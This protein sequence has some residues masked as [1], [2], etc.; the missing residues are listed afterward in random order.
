MSGDCPDEMMAALTRD[1]PDA[2]RALCPLERPLADERVKTV[3]L[4][5]YGALRRAM[6][7]I[8]VTGADL[9]DVLQEIF[10][11]FTR[12]MAEVSPASERSFLLQVGFRIVHTRRRAYVRRKETL[13]DS[14]DDAAPVGPAPST[15]EDLMSHRE[16]IELLDRLLRAMPADLRTV[17]VLC[18]VEEATIEEAA[19]ILD[20]KVGTVASRLFR[21]RE[22]FDKLATRARA[23]QTGRSR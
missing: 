4:T 10:V 3:V 8:G 14:I 12:R 11:V 19:H 21:A 1:R 20:L 18:E 9:D 15:P 22:L 6:R 5:H 7:R 23:T 2:L 17:L 16:Q 13:D